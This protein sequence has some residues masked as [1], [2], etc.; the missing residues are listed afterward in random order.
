MTA[1]IVFAAAGFTALP[2]APG[3]N[4]D[5]DKPDDFASRLGDA[6]G[7]GDIDLADFGVLQWCFAAVGDG[8]CIQWFDFNTNGRIDLDDY[9]AFHGSGAGDPCTTRMILRCNQAVVVD[10]STAPPV[11]DWPRGAC[12]TGAGEGLVILEFV[13]TGVSA[14]IRTDVNITPPADD[15]ELAVYA[16]DQLDVCDSSAWIQWG[17]SEDEGAGNNSAVCAREL[18]VGARYIVV[19]ASYSPDDRGPYTVT[20]QCPCP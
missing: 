7:D 6:D 4:T 2:G 16:V 12:W 17:C 19:L 13:P 8:R 18:I 3:N 14:R 11:A 1:S 9:A 5:G 20:V 10:N 15:S